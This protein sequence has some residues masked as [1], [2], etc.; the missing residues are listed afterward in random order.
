MTNDASPVLVVGASAAGALTARLLAA[1]GRAVTL[2]DEAAKPGREQ[3]TLI[4]TERLMSVLDPLVAQGCV[5]DQVRSFEMFA[6]GATRRV[7]LKRPDLVIE[8]SVLINDLI[9]AAR[10]AGAEVLPRHRFLGFEGDRYVRIAGPKG[11]VLHLAPVVVGADGAASGVARS[12]GVRHDQLSLLQ[13][14]VPR[15][16]DLREA[17]SRVWFIPR[18]TPYFFW[19]IP[20]GDRRVAVGL[21]SDGRAAI[22]P[23]LT[24]FLDEHHL[25]PTE[26]QAALVP[27]YRRWVPIHR[28]WGERD[29]YLV[30]DAAAQVKLSTV[31]GVVTG[32]RGAA[33]AA[34]MI[35][36]DRARLAGVDLRL[37][38]GV[39]A[40]IRRALHGFD[41]AAYSELLDSL[42][43]KATLAL[44]ATSRDAALPM[45]AR[46][47]VRAP[48]VAFTGMKALLASTS[49]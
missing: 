46:S 49:G 43:G 19:M 29:I 20:E 32:F 16:D 11:E 25:T 8:R 2:I 34:R 30:G 18:L 28:R 22:R 6:D 23:L 42:S 39:H 1:S 40:L 33:A 41:E 31:G 7:E 12:I 17:T 48:R 24:R 3:R 4:V 36:A 35:L 13:A 26:Y 9:G 14:V 37:D 15:P 47:L 38:L 44:G 27:R 10:S 21:I 45:L 5:R